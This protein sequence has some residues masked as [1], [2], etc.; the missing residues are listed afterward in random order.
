MCVI[1][2]Y[3]MRTSLTTTALLASL[4]V[5]GCS[6]TS[7]MDTLGVGKQTPDERLVSTNPPLTVPPDMQL[8]PPSGTQTARQA[9]AAVP[10]R[11]LANPPAYGSAPAAP[12]RTTAAAPTSPAADNVDAQGRSISSYD[13]IYIKHGIDVY[14]PDGTH[15]KTVELNRE[16]AERIKAEKK[17]K[18]PNYGTIFNIGN[19][20]KD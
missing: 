19:I 17:A 5:G 15:K 1:L 3:R 16:L 10:A 11:T 14:N 4:L 13:K 2:G 8:R 20:F 6:E 18:N 7:F 9:Q 12:A